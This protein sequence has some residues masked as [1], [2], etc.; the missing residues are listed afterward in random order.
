MSEILLDSQAFFHNLTL[1]SQHLK[2]YSTSTRLAL[3]LKDN[4]Y[5]HGLREIATLARD[6]GVQDVFVKT[7]CEAKIVQSLFGSITILYGMP[8]EPLAPNMAIAINNKEILESLCPGQ[9]VELKV[10]TGMNRN[11]ISPDE[12]EEYITLIAQKGLELFGVFSHNGYGDEVGEDFALGCENFHTLKDKVASI[13]AG[14]GIVLPRFHM[15]N[16]SGTLRAT[17]IDDDLVRVGIAAYG[18][19][20]CDIDLEIATQL[21]PVASLWAD[22]ISR[23]ILPKGAKIGYGGKSV[24]AQESVISTYDVGYGDG[25]YR[26]NE[27][28]NLHTADG[29]RILPRTSMDCFSCASDMPRICVFDNASLV[30]REFD[31]ISYEVLTRLSPFIKRTIV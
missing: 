14:L 6:F 4:A 3:V 21:K 24:L 10:N 11:G 31:T 16:S 25:L 12:V 20:E 26:V 18:Y 19:L 1:I 22:R 15:L 23:K 2:T 7:H 29:Q 17:H 27:H 13:C 28:K 30:A 9:R 5:G 8:Q